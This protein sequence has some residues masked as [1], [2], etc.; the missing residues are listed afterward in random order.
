MGGF[1]EE[2]IASEEARRRE[3]PVVAHRIFLAHA[4]VAP[5]PRAAAEAMR[6]FVRQAS[7]DHQESGSIARKVESAR[8]LAAEMLGCAPGEIALL[9]P[10]SLGLNL[11]ANGL[12]WRRG[13]E[14]VYYHGD[15]PANVYPWSNLAAQGVKTISLEPAAPGRITWDL[16]E[17]QLSG[18]T[19]LV[20]LATCHFLSG[21]RID[22]ET[23][24]RNLGERG[25][26]FCLDGIQT[27]GAFPLSVRHVDFLS[28]DS[29]KWL[30][31]PLGAG[32][33]YVKRSRFEELRPTLLGSW[34]V[35]SPDFV[36]QKEISFH[37]QAR[38]YEPGA[39]NVPGIIG[40]GG[41]LELLRRAGIAAVTERLLYLRK[42]IVERVR[43][44]G[45]LIYGEEDVPA[46]AGDEEGRS[47][48]LSLS[49]P[50]CDMAELFEK[51]VRRGISVSLR[52]T[53]EGEALV[54]ISPH[55]YNTEAEIEQLT[56]S[57]A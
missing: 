38:R 32:I 55:F 34:N 18:R 17:E 27:L 52:R 13:D 9:G 16:V 1:V 53:G 21:Y 44:L 36:A 22:V 41:S 47:G 19:R 30:L 4:G 15:Y 37:S 3:F 42:C 14:V 43:P 39:L 2:I 11:V 23:I 48:I 56:E 49:R 26:L 7:R 12:S 57:L 5:L 46:A 40:M 25:V 45:Y 20:A 24:G 29:H 35:D 31:G 51:L 28:A 6:G 50:G 10:T 54:R 33:F 8:G